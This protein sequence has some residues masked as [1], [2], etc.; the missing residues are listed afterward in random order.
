ME[1][2]ADKPA[3]SKLFGCYIAVNAE[4]PGQVSIEI[5][6]IILQ[7]CRVKSYPQL[8]ISN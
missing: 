5:S 8:A 7:S 1:I 4:F 3:S 2:E 6:I